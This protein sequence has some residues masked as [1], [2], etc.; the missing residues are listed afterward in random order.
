MLS[1]PRTPEGKI[2]A[3]HR[4]ASLLT[5][6]HETAQITIIGY[7]VSDFFVKL[8]GGYIRSAGPPFPKRSMGPR[9]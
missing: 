7:V 6:E 5:D 1:K 4:V 8:K 2:I 3:I 9:Q